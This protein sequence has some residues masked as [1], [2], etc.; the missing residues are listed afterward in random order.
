MR[1]AYRIAL[2]SFVVALPLLMA[3]TGGLPS[4]PRFQS[5]GVNV[6]APATGN[7]TASGTVT[8]ASVTATGTVTGATVNATSTLQLG[9]VAVLPEIICATTGGCNIST[10]AVNQ[11]AFLQKGAFTDRSST[12]A[13]AMDPD[14]Q[15]TIN[16][17]HR[18]VVDF[19]FTWTNITTNTQGIK[20][21]WGQAS[22]GS[23][24]G[25]LI[26]NHDGTANGS[27]GGVVTGLVLQADVGSGAIV[28]GAI[29]AAQNNYCGSGFATPNATDLGILWAQG[30]SNAN[31]TRFLGGQ[32]SWIRMRRVS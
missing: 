2:V 24:N 6:A 8:G 13:F 19:C 27:S 1:R 23:G 11:S 30:A 22:G 14:L 16:A 18:F 28:G 7:L 10:I 26:G 32:G 29:S 3:P 12:V 25:K 31:A 17:A 5:V 20:F 9:G 4:R 21:E 15:F